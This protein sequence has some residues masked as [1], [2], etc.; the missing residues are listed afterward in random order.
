[1]YTFG[2]EVEYN[3]Y[4][5][6]EYEL[7]VLKKARE[8]QI[9]LHDRKQLIKE[10]IDMADICLSGNRDKVKPLAAYLQIPYFLWCIFAAVLNYSVY[11]LN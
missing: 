11:R 2:L 3:I 4:K 8:S 9:S 5:A 6:A 10:I 1:M 7:M